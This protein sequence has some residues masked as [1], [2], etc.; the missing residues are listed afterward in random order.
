MQACGILWEC[1]GLLSAK[2]VLKVEE[3]PLNSKS[4]KAASEKAIQESNLRQDLVVIQYLEVRG[5][6]SKHPTPPRI[7]GVDSAETQLVCEG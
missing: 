6:G 3:Q 1:S 2:R 5:Q 7:V 4:E